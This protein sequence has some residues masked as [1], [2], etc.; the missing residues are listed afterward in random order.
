VLS[1]LTA[2]K[3]S[4]WSSHA[5]DLEEINLAICA[6]MAHSVAAMADPGS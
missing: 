2:N 5:L 6:I 1:R 3:P 4:P